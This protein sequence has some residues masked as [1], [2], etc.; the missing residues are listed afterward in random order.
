MKFYHRTTTDNWEKIQKEG[1]LW[2]IGMSYRHTYL[3]PYDWGES[4]GDVLLE[5][6]YEPT[7]VIGIDNYGFDPPLGEICVQ[8]S[9]FVPISLEHI[10]KIN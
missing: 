4:Y 8:F 7:D 3:A 5:V 6:E 2:G 1:V 10:K 9:V